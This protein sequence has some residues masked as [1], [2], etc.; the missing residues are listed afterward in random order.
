MARFSGCDKVQKRC[1]IVCS[2]RRR[3]AG[4]RDRSGGATRDAVK[5]AGAPAAPPVELGAARRPDPAACVA[6]VVVVVVVVVLCSST[7][8]SSASHSLSSRFSFDSRSLSLSLSAPF[9]APVK[10]KRCCRLSR[11]CPASTD[12]DSSA[13][14]AAAAAAAA[15]RDTPNHLSGFPTSSAADARRFSDNTAAVLVCA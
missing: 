7:S 15:G 9:A 8:S 11:R 3:E 13:A 1:S 12:G 6:S 4:A 2:E 5:G 10:V 14:A